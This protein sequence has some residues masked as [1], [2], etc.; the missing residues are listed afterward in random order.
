MKQQKA[1]RGK[2]GG[3][4]VWKRGGVDGCGRLG[5]G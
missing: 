5:Q 4:A 3:R 1:Q 2:G